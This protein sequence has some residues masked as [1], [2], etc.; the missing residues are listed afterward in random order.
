MA[1]T[2]NIADTGGERLYNIDKN[3]TC[4]DLS[5]L[6]LTPKTT[7]KKRTKSVDTEYS[8]RKKWMKINKKM[9]ESGANNEQLEVNPT[10][11]TNKASPRLSVYGL[12]QEMKT[13]FAGLDKSMDVKL[14][15][16]TLNMQA[17]FN[18]LVKKTVH[19]E[20]THVTEKVEALK[21]QVDQGEKLNLFA[22]GLGEGLMMDVC[23]IAGRVTLLEGECTAT[24]HHLA[25]MEADLNELN[26]RTKHAVALASS[27]PEEQDNGQTNQMQSTTTC[28]VVIKNLTEVENEVIDD[29]VNKLF[30]SGL[31]L[32]AVK[33]V[34]AERKISKTRYPGVVMVT[35]DN[36]ETKHEILKVKRVLRS[37]DK[38]RNV[39]IE[40][41]LPPE[42]RLYE[43]N[44]RTLLRATGTDSKFRLQGG[45]LRS[46][47][48]PVSY[49]RPNHSGNRSKRDRDESLLDRVSA[50]QEEYRRQPSRGRSSRNGDRY[51]YRPESTPAQ[52]PR[53]QRTSEMNR[54]EHELSNID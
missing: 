9:N 23:D 8:P 30:V 29:E 48:P 6:G 47:R 53:N 31:E 12:Q 5:G 41:E 36:Q 3:T 34:H 22:K 14:E 33:I 7:G 50:Q 54:K 21:S 1:G 15:K 52:P 44:M 32:K 45:V 26:R 51:F 11:K 24:E 19:E 17:H 37:C 43:Q 10:E 25:T 38:Y 40:P 27:R 16:M 20:L 28:K 4:I 46:T 2:N 49:S 39:Y 42:R 18:E 13:M 35:L